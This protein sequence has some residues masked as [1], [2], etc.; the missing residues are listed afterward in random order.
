[1]ADGIVIV[2]RTGMIRFAN[3]AAER[4]FGRSASELLDRELG[5]PVLAAETAE[6][7]VVRP[8]QQTVT[9]ELRAVETEWQGEPSHLLSL[10][11]VTDRKR[12][13]QRTAQL[14][15]ERIARIEAEAA[16]HAKSEFLAL[17]SHELRTPLNAV[18]GY[19]ELLDLGI[20][21]PLSPDQ[22]KQIGRIMHSG[23]HLLGLV[24]EVLDLAKVEAGALSL[25]R[26]IGRPGKSIDAALALVEPVAQAKGVNLI[27]KMP[28]EENVTYAGDDGRVRQILVNLLNN[29]VK[30]TPAGGEVRMEWGVTAVP[31]TEAQLFGRGPWCYLRISDTGI[32]I[33]K[34][35]LGS[36]FEPF[37]QVEAGHTRS[38]EG[39]GLGLTISRR[40]ARLMNGDLSVRSEVGKGSIFVLWLPDATTMARD[41]ARWRAEAPEMAARLLGLGD[42]GKIL[43]REFAP[44]LDAFVARLRDDVLAEGVQT[45]RYCELSDHMGAFVADVAIML[46][47]IEEGQGKPSVI[48]SDATKIQLVIAESHGAQRAEYGWTADVLHDE[49]AI[50]HDEIERLIHLHRRGI[51][52]AAFDEARIVIGRVI[53]Q[54]VE[55][56][57]RAL[58]RAAAASES[59]ALIR[60][61]SR[62]QPYI[63]AD[64]V[65]GKKT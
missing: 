55:A 29:A 6:V 16:N 21:G 39:S 58:N 30:F 54:A 17:M 60:E 13:E 8:N 4:L 2:S 62:P 47:A 14:N 44:L 53:D 52:D 5:F 59:T 1:M 45:L 9:A 57:C 11:D 48:V 26:G 65:V 56:S 19:A 61:T 28:P 46:A 42:V 37:V 64:E 38:Q 36:I 32:G 33:P 12:A 22:H 49:W 20:T 18:I 10:R 23:R 41:T 15:R 7:E 35:K 27:R 3:P 24:N 43:V 50:L 31:D 51:P 40:L 63:D 25:Q 34:K